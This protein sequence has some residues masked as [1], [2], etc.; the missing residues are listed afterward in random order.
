MLNRSGQAG[1]AREVAVSCGPGLYASPTV[2]NNVE[3]LSACR[4]SWRGGRA[5]SAAS[6]R[7]EP[8]P[9]ALFSAGRCGNRAFTNCRWAYRCATGR[10]L[11]RRL[12][13]GRKIKAVIPGGVSAPPIPEGAGGR[14]GLRLAGCRRLDARSAGVIVI[15]DSTCM[16][17]V[18][19]GSS[20][21]STMNPRQVQPCR[22]GLNW[23]VKVLRRVEAG[24][25]AG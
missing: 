4:I 13:P 2:I 6:A 20:S 10:G 16:V 9:E 21:S 18:A 15:D 11:R 23:D 7:K 1:E 24:R 22:E 19:T 17:K 12:P 25:G 14:D 3:T 8:W 5:G